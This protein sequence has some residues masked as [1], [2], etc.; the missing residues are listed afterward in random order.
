M[1]D[2]AACDVAIV[3]GDLGAGGAQRVVVSLAESWAKMGFKV[4]LITRQSTVEDFF[5]LAPTVRRIALED[6]GASAS[7]V[8]ALA[9]NIQRIVRLRRAFSDCGAPVVVSFIAETNILATLAAFF[10]PARLVISE[11]NDPRRQSLGRLWNLLRRCVYRFADGVTANSRGALEGL[12]QFVPAAKLA[13]VP[14]PLLLP[15][16]A[17]AE[18]QPIILNV[19]RFHRQ[20]A[21]DVL[22]AAFAE[23]AARHP[24][25]KLAFLGSGPLR[26]NLQAQAEE[27]NIAGRVEWLAPTA[28]PYPHY[29]EASIF[30]LPSR[31]EG[32]PNALL[33]AMGMGLAAV[34]SN[35]S[36][37][38]L[39][40]IEDDINGL[41][42]PVDDP[43]ALAAALDRLIRDADLR[44]RLG[45]KALQVRQTHAI[46]VV[47][48]R[49]N[50]VLKLAV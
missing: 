1:N 30:A 49:W 17:D 20:K 48:A 4:A 13:F 29:A 26:A 12:G 3:I 9:A 31:Y 21:Q 19:G 18:S 42:V 36:P 37:G 8:A 44:R 45:S 39:E 33:E 22:I 24:D 15:A 50:K 27:L 40:V 11:R 34:V 28:T 41:I 43:L 38:P 7:L 46:E 16:I 35:A 23:I 32:T 14:N 25:W 2:N 6:P 5:S 47:I 10:H